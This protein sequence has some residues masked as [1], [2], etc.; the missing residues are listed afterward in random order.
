MRG[1]LYAEAR[2]ICRNTCA[3]MMYSATPASPSSAEASSDLT[4]SS[5]GSAG[6]I[7]LKL[8]HTW[9]YPKTIDEEG[10]PPPAF[11]SALMRKMV[12]RNSIVSSL[13]E[14]VPFPAEAVLKCSIVK[15]QQQ[16]GKGSSF[17]KNG[18]HSAWICAGQEIWSREVAIWSRDSSSIASLQMVPKL[19]GLQGDVV[20]EASA[21]SRG[22]KAPDVVS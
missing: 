19:E 14:A 15:C 18:G 10:S 20:A 2:I 17:T 22:L 12:L 9:P 4:S 3:E 13:L 11:I 6:A 21:S 16:K 8:G 7:Y 5:A 1:G